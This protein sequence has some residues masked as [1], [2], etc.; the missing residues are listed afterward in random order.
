MSIGGRVKLARKAA[1]LTQSDLAEKVGIKQSTISELERG[2]SRSTTHLALIAKFCSVSTEYLQGISDSSLPIN[3]APDPSNLGGERLHVARYVP[4]ISLVQAGEW[5]EVSVQQDLDSAV[6]WPCPVKCGPDTFALRVEGL[7]MSP[8]FPPG[9]II[10]V[11]PEVQPESGKKV[12]AF[13][14]D[15]NTATFKQYFEDAGKKFLKAMNP[16]WPTQ[17]TE[18]NGNCRIIGTVVSAGFET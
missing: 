13:L 2:D 8:D 12:V 4:E 3:Y 6:H 11:D 17:Y 9:I 16:D 5:T 1:G 14:E 7:S 15:E 18:I 10:F